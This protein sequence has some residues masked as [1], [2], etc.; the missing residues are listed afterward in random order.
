M[1]SRVSY[2]ITT[3]PGVK[4]Q[5]VMDSIV[6]YEVVYM[7]YGATV[8]DPQ[9]PPFTSPMTYFDVLKLDSLIPIPPVTLDVSFSVPG[10]ATNFTT[11]VEGLVPQFGVEPKYGVR[12]VR[13]I[14]YI[15]VRA[16][17]GSRV[18]FQVETL[19]TQKTQASMDAI[20]SY[21]IS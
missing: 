6:S 13:G 7:G 3:V 16:F 19:P 2:E 15:Q 20:I 11:R 10:R 21:I 9:S 17:M 12:G 4:P 18:M 5:G 8:V 1:D 14:A